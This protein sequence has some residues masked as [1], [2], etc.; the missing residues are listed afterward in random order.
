MLNLVS[1]DMLL[2]ML[3]VTLGF[4]GGWIVKE[5]F[6]KCPDCVCPECPPQNVTNLIINN[7]KLKVKGGG[8]LDLTNVLKDNQIIQ[9]S[10]STGLKDTLEQKKKGFLKRIF[11]KK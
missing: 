5:Q 1:R 4:F 11:S 7:E 6:S 2:A 10:D 9:R 3:F 8:S